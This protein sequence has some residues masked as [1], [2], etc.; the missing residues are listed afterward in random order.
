MID[1]VQNLASLVLVLTTLKNF[2]VEAFHSTVNI[3]AGVMSFGNFGLIAGGVG[4]GRGL[5]YLSSGSKVCTAADKMI[6]SDLFLLP[7]C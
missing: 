2:R 7:G 3:P 4:G 6:E 1:L 5:T